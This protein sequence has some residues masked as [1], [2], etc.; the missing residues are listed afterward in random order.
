M[1]EKFTRGLL[2]RMGREVRSNLGLSHL[3]LLE[4]IKDAEAELREEDTAEDR[5]D[6]LLVCEFYFVVCFGASLRGCEGFMIERS[7]LVK[8]I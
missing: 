2:S 6:F 5:R 1:V 4:M 7:D 3:V 8:N